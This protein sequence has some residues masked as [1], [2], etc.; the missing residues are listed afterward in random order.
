MQMKGYKLISPG[1]II[2]RWQGDY[3]SDG[4]VTWKPVTETSVTCT[5]ASIDRGML[6]RVQDWVV[7]RR[8]DQA[9]TKDEPRRP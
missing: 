3:S 4:G 2:D 5:Q 9:N 1:E 6:Y 7:P 8:V